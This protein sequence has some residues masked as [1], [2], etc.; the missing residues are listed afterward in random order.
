MT[1]EKRAALRQSSPVR[2]LWW[3]LKRPYWS[4]R[5]RWNPALERRTEE[6]CTIQAAQQALNHS[7]TTMIEA[8]QTEEKK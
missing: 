6:R 2:R 3:M 8:F 5:V 4:L 1:D 7:L